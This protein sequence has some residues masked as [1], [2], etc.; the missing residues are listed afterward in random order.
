MDL[1]A[2]STFIFFMLFVIHDFTQLD[3]KTIQIST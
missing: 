3:L 2:N 1:I